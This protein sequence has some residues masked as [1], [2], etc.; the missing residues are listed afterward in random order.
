MMHADVLPSTF[1]GHVLPGCAFI[2]WALY[3][4]VHAIVGGQNGPPSVS[5]EQT[6]FLPVFKVTV[7]L[8][9]VWVEIPGEGWYPQDV[10]MS[11]QHVTMYSVFGLSGVVDL[12]ARRGLLSSGATYV[13]YAAAMVN[14]GFLFWAHS[15]HGGV[16]G[17]VHLVLALAFFFAAAVALVETLR[18]SAG[19]AW[20]RIGAQLVLGSWF[21]VGGWILYRSGWD[22]ADPARMG[23]TYMAFS[24]TAIGGSVVTVGARLAAGARSG[25]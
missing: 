10:M 7:A 9:G 12:M 3:W 19:L 13:A 1:L 21:V 2:A 22:L 5:L 11:W 14:S 23:W 6:V 18:P 24:W 15:S 16:E 17:L 8:V 25:A 20:G 4:A